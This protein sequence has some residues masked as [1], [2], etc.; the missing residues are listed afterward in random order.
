MIKTPEPS[1]Y[2]GIYGDYKQD[3][4]LY[5]YPANSS[6]GKSVRTDN[7]RY[8]KI[9]MAT[10]TSILGFGSGDAT[11]KAAMKNGNITKID[12]VEYESTNVLGVYARLTVI[13]YGE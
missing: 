7:R 3:Y 5:M 13:V 11:I 12:H 1:I 2:S 6:I 8:T 9:G 4:P 10:V